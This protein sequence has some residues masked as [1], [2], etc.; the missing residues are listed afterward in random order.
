[1]VDVT[2]IITTGNLKRS[3]NQAA[4]YSEQ[5]SEVSTQICLLRQGQRENEST[6]HHKLL[7]VLDNIRD[8]LAPGFSSLCFLLE[9]K[10]AV[11]GSR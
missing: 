2:H 6:V 9:I 11:L 5:G 10:I 8:I 7:E 3:H 1:M 4:G